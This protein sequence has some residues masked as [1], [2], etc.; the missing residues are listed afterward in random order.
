MEEELKFYRKIMAPELEKEGLAIDSL[1]ISKTDDPDEFHFRLT[2]IQAGKQSQFL[3]GNIIIKV[4]GLLNGKQTEY[5]F[6]ELGTFN[7]KH[8]QFQ[9]KYF[10]NIQG[11]ITLPSNFE[12]KSIS[13]NVKTKGLRKN[14]KADNKLN[15]QPVE[16]QNYVR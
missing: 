16:S 5:D 6:R 1:D 7:N 15:W 11:F 13:V 14:Q 8:F 9:F 3:K 2:L 4:T 12:A 10:Q